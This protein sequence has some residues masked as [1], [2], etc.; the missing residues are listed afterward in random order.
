DRPDWVS[1]PLVAALAGDAEARAVV[2]GAEAEQEVPEVPEDELVAAVDPG[3]RAVLSRVLAG[4]D[5]AV[6]SPPGTGSLDLVVVLAEELNAR[7]RSV[8]VV[9]RR[10]R[11]LA[12][13]VAIAQQRG[14]DELVFDLSPDPSLQRNASAA[15][16]RSLR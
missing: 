11:N 3:H 7:G 15:L 5:L 13:L 4:Q 16:L 8:L 6:A 10:R 12:Q 2:R 1:S 14:L 9:S